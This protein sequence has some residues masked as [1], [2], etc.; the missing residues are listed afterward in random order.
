MEHRADGPGETG[1]AL[2]PVNLG[3]GRTAK[4]LTVG[5]IYACALLDDGSVKCWG[6][7]YW[8]QLG[9][10]DTEHRGDNPGEMGEALP[11]VAL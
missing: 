2:P 9:L 8:G 11:A 1:D 7:N 6:G 4:A 10:D 3:T 5:D